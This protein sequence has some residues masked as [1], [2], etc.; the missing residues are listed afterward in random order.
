MPARTHGMR[1]TAVYYVW[2]SMRARCRNKNNPY[3]KNYGGRGIFVCERWHKFENFFADMGH[4]PGGMSIDRI[5]NDGPYSPEN[6]RWATR[7]EQSN[8]QRTRNDAPYIEHNGQRFRITEL[9]R[10]LGLSYGA[11]YSRLLR[12]RL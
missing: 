7:K 12:S 10:K 11:I 2:V 3:Y 9:A 5:N 1:S 8:N 4:P 6:C